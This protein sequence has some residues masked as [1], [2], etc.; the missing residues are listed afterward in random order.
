MD[1]ELS[2]SAKTT[3][4]A[5]VR[6][7][8]GKPVVVW[9]TVDVLRHDGTKAFSFKSEAKEIASWGK[10]ESSLSIVPTDAYKKDE[11]VTTF[12]QQRTRQRRQ[13]LIPSMSAW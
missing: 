13:E 5:E 7:E 3:V 4:E 2:G 11:N 12:Q 8:T 10:E 1:M 9:T 6:N